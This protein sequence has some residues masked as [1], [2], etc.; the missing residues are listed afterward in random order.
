VS[1]I[2]RHLLIKQASMILGGAKNFGSSAWQRLRLSV[3]TLAR[4]V[5]L[6]FHHTCERLGL[7]NPPPARIK[8][9]ASIPSEGIAFLPQDRFERPVAEQAARANVLRRHASC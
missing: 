7:S 8:R 3:R 1:K 4:G 6:S 9:A 2:K 5:S